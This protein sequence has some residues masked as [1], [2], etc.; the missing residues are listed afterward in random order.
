MATVATLADDRSY[1]IPLA[2]EY[3]REARSCYTNGVYGSSV[4]SGR[5]YSNKALVAARGVREPWTPPSVRWYNVEGVR[6]VRDCGG[7]N[8][9]REGVVIR[10][11]ELDSAAVAGR[12][13]ANNPDSKKRNYGD[14][15][16]VGRR[17][18]RE[19][20]GVKTDLDL[21]GVGKKIGRSAIGDDVKHVVAPV[22]AYMKLFD[23]PEPVAGCLRTFA[24]PENYP[25]YIHCAGGA[26][27]TGCI[28]FLLEGLCG[29]GEADLSIDYE[30]TSFGIE[31]RH[32]T[33]G[34]YKF[35]SFVGKV[36]AYPGDSLK[37]KIE[38]F[39]V[40]ELGLSKEEIASI[41]AILTK[42]GAR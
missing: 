30:L 40:S 27:R 2:D 29:V 22:G 16:E 35:A 11:G 3:V 1:A 25:V 19:K 23:R 34:T 7:W 17:T 32:R 20:L 39:A 5:K 12:R 37:D 10:G 18:M 24:R 15:T 33:D 41:R 4:L 14:V 9:L 31:R 26:D 6:N 36:K 42:K 8:G 21:R 28:L 13:D 38:S